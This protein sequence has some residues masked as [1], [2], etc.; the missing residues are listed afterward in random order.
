[1]LK[2]SPHYT[3]ELTKEY[4]AVLILNLLVCFI[5]LT[6]LV[7]V[8]RL[9]P[10]VREPD[11]GLIVLLLWSD[12]IWSADKMISTII[13]FFITNLDNYI[14]WISDTVQ[15]ACLGINISLA[16]IISYTAKSR[17]YEQSDFMK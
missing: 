3:I 1:M 15:L 10:R 9:V 5:D 11:V 7:R 17:L 8:L 16:V 12:L 4:T 6:L 2:H 13:H 14:Y